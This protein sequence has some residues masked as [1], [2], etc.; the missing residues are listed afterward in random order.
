MRI[1][2]P[3]APLALVLAGT[4]G[5]ALV[6]QDAD[7]STM[8]TALTP[9]GDGLSIALPDDPKATV[10]VTP[11][12]E[13]A[14]DPSGGDGCSVRNGTVDIET[15]GDLRQILVSRWSTSCQAIEFLNGRHG[16]F[17]DVS[18]VPGAENVTEITSD[19]GP[20]TYFEHD[21]TE[22]TNSC[23]T[24]SMSYALLVSEEPADAEHPVL[25]LIDPTEGQIDLR[26][27]AATLAPDA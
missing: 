14:E 15:G 12:G 27:Y 16:Y 22:C 19:A 17:S 20:V 9:I 2:W 11:L 21:Y 5:C 3:V 1:Q 7:L 6:R 25:V 4:T 13:P 23:E 24:W 18:Q 8:A 26:Q 10:T